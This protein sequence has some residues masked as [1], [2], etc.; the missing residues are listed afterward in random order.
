LEDLFIWSEIQELRKKIEHHNQL[1]YQLA[2]PEISDFE[3]DQLVKKLQD[4]E[5]KYPIYKSSDSPTEKVG[6][7]IQKTEKIIAHKKRMYSLE[8]AYS[9]EE[10]MSFLQKIFPNSDYDFVAQEKIDG[11]SI[12]LFYNNGKLQYATTRGDGLEGEDVTANVSTIDAIPQNIPYRKPLE[13]RGEIFLPKFDFERLNAE[14]E[15]L[16]E[17]LFSNP[18]N[19]A[20]G[21]IKLKDSRVVKKRN[22]QAFFYTV[23]FFEDEKVTT[24]MELIQFLQ[25]QHFP[26]LTEM[27]HF[28]SDS[29]SQLK[30]EF[31]KYADYLN[32]ERHTLQY[33]ID[34]IVIKANHFSWQRQLGF[35]NKNPKWAIAYKFKAEEAETILEDVSFQVGRTGAITPVARLRPVQISGSVVS[36][37]TL[38]NAEEIKRLDLRIGDSVKII[39]SGEIIPKIIDVIKNTNRNCFSPVVF[40]EKCPACN[41]ALARDE[42]GV[43]TYCENINCPA[44]ITRR[45]EHFSSREAVDIEGLGTSWIKKLHEHGL[46]QK[47]EDIY[48]LDFHQIEVMEKQGKK[49]VENLKA[50][51]EKSKQQKFYKILFGLG[52]RFVG[53][54]ISQILAHHFGNIDKLM[55]ADRESLLA[56]PEIGEKIAD[57]ILSFLADEKNVETIE[58]LK[59]AG[60]RLEN[61]ISEKQKGKFSGKKFLATGS[62][63]RFTRNQVKEMVEEHGGEFI[64][65]VSKNLD[66]LIVGENAGSKLAKAK[67]ISSILIINEEEF[68]KLI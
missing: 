29:L 63:Q 56:I 57:S 13:A 11:F 5:E 38:H 44:Q 2:K 19:A 53:A 28:K 67:K 37:A 62:L 3:Y 15:Y 10:L 65:S 55:E 42:E 17:K 39:K 9:L 54:K 68:E 1:Y 48:Q 61:E 41:S 21:S 22:L 31:E 47:I 18:R 7:D 16:G 12:N 58:A 64:S 40:P 45:I 6:S 20:A 36:N 27:K 34:G 25:K 35:T 14:R 4:L 43:I 26:I 60:V 23:G 24:E 51:I 33:D 46:L 66:Y 32:H 30:D 50:A 8:N 59:K 52:I 49:S